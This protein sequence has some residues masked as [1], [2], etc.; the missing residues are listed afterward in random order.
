MS[1][2][3]IDGILALVAAVMGILCFALD[4]PQSVEMVMR[5]V[6]VALVA[7]AVFFLLGEFLFYKEVLDPFFKKEESSNVICTRKASG[8]TKRRIII[9]W[10]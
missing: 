10:I 7:L 4:M 5:I 1:W 9:K 6:S 2:V 3:M 8:E